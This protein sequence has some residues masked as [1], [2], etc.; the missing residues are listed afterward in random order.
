M[1]Y[2]NKNDVRGIVI[3]KKAKNGLSKGTNKK[4][5][6]T[7]MKFLPVAIIESIR[8]FLAYALFKDFVVYQMDAKSSFLYGKIEEEVYVCQ[9]PGFEDLDFPDRVYK[10][11]K[12]LYGLHQ[13]P[14]AWYE[15]LSI[16]LLENRFQRGQID[17]TLFIKR[18]QGIG[19]NAGNLKLMLLGIN[20]LLLEKVNAG[21]HNLL[22]L[23]WRFTK[24]I[25]SGKGVWCGEEQV[26][27]RE[28]GSGEGER[29]STEDAKGTDCLPNATIFEQL[30]H[31]G[32]EKLSQ[33]L[34]FYKAF[35][36]PQWNWWRFLKLNNLLEF[37]PNYNREV[38]DL[39]NTKTAQALEIQILHKLFPSEDK[40]LGDQ[41]DASK[42]GRKIDDIDK[43][44]EV[45]LVDET[46]GRYGDD[47]MFDTT[48]LDGEEVF[49]GQD[50]VEKEVSTTDPVTTVGEVVTTAS[51]EVSAAS[52]IP[53]LV[54]AEN[55]HNST[56]NKPKAKSITFRDLGEST[57]RTTLTPIPSNIKDKGKAKMIEPEKPL[58]KK[59]QI[60]L[61]EELSFKLQA[62]EE[63]QVRLAREKAEK[64]EE[65]NISWD[66]V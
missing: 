21:R 58:K 3:M 38:L 46:H 35:F 24:N 22:L 60:R 59:E 29:S 11:E 50:V 12:A 1:V 52:A 14:R 28:V 62:E 40:G 43:D 61:D 25:R 13:A 41:E 44:A 10:I 16:Y 36:S 17:K 39:G 37:V 27:R 53:V 57:T 8:L 51:V 9:P 31:M 48:I 7:M 34:T 2:R 47:L 15:T 45:T 18:E 5:G 20:L 64:V 23:V 65:A 54:L 6:L 63:E 4:K 30:T 66:N 26:K 33:K 55:N 32:Y 49:V 42:Q 56:L 19:V